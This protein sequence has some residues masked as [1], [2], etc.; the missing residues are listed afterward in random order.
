MGQGD[1]DTIRSD[2]QDSPQFN[3]GHEI[4]SDC[5]NDEL[6]KS[7]CRSMFL[8]YLLS[9]FQLFWSVYSAHPDVGTWNMAHEHHSSSL[10]R[11]TTAQQNALMKA[12]KG[13]CLQDVDS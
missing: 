9:H 4:R 12:K 1:K 2:A 7:V 5:S 8:L 10:S 11:R 6:T 3:L 13:T